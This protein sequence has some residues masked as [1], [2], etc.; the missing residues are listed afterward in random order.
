MMTAMVLCME[1]RSHY[2]SI[3]ERDSIPLK[4]QK[5]MQSMWPFCCTITKRCK[6]YFNLWPKEI[7]GQE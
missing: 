1:K 2:G 3:M 6:I 5:R 7:Y 4:M